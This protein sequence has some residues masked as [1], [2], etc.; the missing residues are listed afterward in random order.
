[1]AIRANGNVTKK[2]PEKKKLYEFMTRDTMNVEHKMFDNTGNNWS[3][4]N[5][6]KS[7]KEKFG[8]HTRKTLNI[9]SKKT[10]GFGTSH[11]KRKVLQCETERLSVGDHCWF[12][13]C[14]G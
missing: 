10:A 4:W 8:G 9:F 14:T 13:I 2:E 5:S 11:I 3:N 6:N 12:R 7:L 1:V